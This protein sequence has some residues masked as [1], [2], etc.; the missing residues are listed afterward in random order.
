MDKEEFNSGT[1]ILKLRTLA[2][3]NNSEMIFPEHEKLPEN[4]VLDLEYSVFIPKRT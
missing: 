1:G 2:S 4:I 3:K